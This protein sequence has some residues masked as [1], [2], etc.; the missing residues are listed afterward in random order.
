VLSHQ[1]KREK[2]K[3]VWRQVCEWLSEAAALLFLLRPAVA[4]GLIYADLTSE[5]NTHLDLQALFT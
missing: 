1:R 4:A 2:K 5:L 3:Q